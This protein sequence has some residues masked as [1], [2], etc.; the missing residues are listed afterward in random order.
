MS[1]DPKTVRAMKDLENVIIGLGFQAPS[2]TESIIVSP[3]GA[4]EE[5][6][7]PLLDI[8][9]TLGVVGSLGEPQVTLTK[10]LRQRATVCDLAFLSIVRG[11][12]RLL[13]G[14]SGVEV[15]LLSLSLL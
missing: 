9:C 14:R 12:Q 5:G 4:A 15:S 10:L 13:F 3:P 8:F 7:P 11:E 6:R 1:L 2:S